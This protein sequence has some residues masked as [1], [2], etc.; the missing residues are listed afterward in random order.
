MVEKILI[1]LVVILTL[2]SVGKLLNIGELINQ[3]RGRKSYEISEKENNWNA[4]LCLLMLFFGWAIYFYFHNKY[5]AS[6]QLLPGAASLHGESIDKLEKVSFIIISIA[7]LLVQPLLWLF[8]FQYRFREGKRAYHFAHNNRLELVWT[9]IPAI[10]FC[11]LIFYGLKIWNDTLEAEIQGEKITVELYARQFDWHARYAGA[12][13]K[14]GEANYSMIPVNMPIENPLGLLTQETIQVQFDSISA[15]RNRVFNKLE[16]FPLTAEIPDLK[17][18]L[19]QYNHQLQLITQFKKTNETTKYVNAYDDIVIVP[20]GEIH[21]PVGMPIELKMRS[22]DVIHSAYLPHFRVHMYCVPGIQTSFSFVPTVT[23]PDMK[24]KLGNPAFDYL[25]YCN[26]ICGSA[27][28]N[29]QMKI[30]ID[31]PADYERWVKKQ[32]T[33]AESLVAAPEAGVEAA[34]PDSVK[35]DATEKAAPIAMHK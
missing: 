9:V 17:K 15:R 16:N 24:A 4:F 3:V 31:S 30:V 12:D 7:Y 23:T 20:G 6:G 18:E 13:K 11:G 2:V 21:F 14:L 1:G 33:F 8:A 26:N 27:H 22:Q 34:K 28:Y 10:V 25:L 32:K 5:V 19:T 29:M 35:P